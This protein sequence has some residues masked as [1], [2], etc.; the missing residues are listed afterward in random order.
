[1]TAKHI[2]STAGKPRR[3]PKGA[4]AAT[5]SVSSVLTQQPQSDPHSVSAA[6]ATVINRTVATHRDALKRLADS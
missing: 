2:T 6:S 3:N 5:L 1:M 4:K